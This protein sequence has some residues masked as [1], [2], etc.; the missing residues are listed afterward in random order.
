MTEQEK[1]D[2]LKEHVREILSLV[3]EDPDREGLH[4][5]VALFRGVG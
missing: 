1:F 3:G 2:K 5:L 4:R